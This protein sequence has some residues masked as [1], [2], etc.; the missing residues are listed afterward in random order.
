MPSPKRAHAVRL[1]RDPL[2]GPSEA[3]DAMR[4]VGELSDI[5][6]SQIGES[7]AQYRKAE[8]CC[9]TSTMAGCLY[10]QWFGNGW[11]PDGAGRPLLSQSLV[12]EDQRRKS[13]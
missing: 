9:S 7:R 5:T 8:A 10:K 6:N 2:S 13:S 3:V 12:P 11:K 1:V 4:Q